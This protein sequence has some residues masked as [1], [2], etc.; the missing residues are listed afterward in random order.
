[1][2]L[3]PDQIRA[4]SHLLD[5]A[6]DLPLAERQAWMAALPA[7]MQPLLPQLQAMLASDS[8]AAPGGPD[9][10][11]LPRLHGLQIEPGAPDALAGE[12]VGPYRLLRELGRG[13][14]GSVWLAE[15]AD[16]IFERQ[17][18]LKLPRLSRSPRLAERMARERQIGARLEHPHIARLYDAGI[19]AA[20]RPYLV[21]E[22]VQGT[23]LLEYAQLQRLGIAQRIG[24]MLQ[25]CAAVAH[26]H[27]LLVVH[28]DL[29]PSNLMVGDDGNVKLLDFGIAKLLDADEGLM[30]SGSDESQRTHT[31][32]YAAPEQLR[33]EP[34]TTATDIYS[35]GVV[36][37]ELLTAHLP[38][39]D[40]DTGL[41]PDLAAVL[42]RAMRHVPAERYSSVER[43]VDDLQRV[44]QHRPVQAEPTRPSHR[45]RLFVRRHRLPLAVATCV[46]LLGLGG[47]LALARQHALEQLQEQRAVQ[48]REFLFDLLE[49]AEPMAGQQAGQVTGA[50]MVQSAVARARK[51]FIQQPALQGRLFTE[52]GIV[53]RRLELPDQALALFREGHALLQAASEPGDPGLHVAQAQLALQW[54]SSDVPDPSQP[55]DALAWQALQGCAAS[56]ASC[57][58]P[59]AYAQMALTISASRRGDEAATLEHAAQA[60]LESD[61]AFGPQDAEAAMARLHQA[62]ALRNAG[63]YTEAAAA[64]GQARSIAEGTALRAADQTSLRLYHALVQADLGQH[65]SA[66]SALQELLADRPA[67]SSLPLLQRLRAQSLYAQGRLT[68]GVQAAQLALDAGRQGN[69]E[70]EQV[71][72]HQAL[73]RLQSALGRHD[74]ALASIQ[75][76]RAGLRRLQFDPAGAEFLRAHRLA[77]EVALRAGRVA[78]AAAELAP[79]PAAH[80]AGGRT[81]APVDLAQVL[82]LQGGLARREAAFAEAARLHAEAAALLADRLPP[83]HPL[84][85]RNAFEASLAQALQPW[86]VAAPLAAAAAAYLA[87]LPADSAWRPMVESVPA[88]PAAGRYLVF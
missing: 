83:T 29:K 77:A 28:R 49:D 35:L 72:A 25:V 55:A 42:R 46:G 84:R 78:E 30:A 21:M 33:G 22:R 79:L 20:G 4:L 86:A 59:R 81:V 82:D 2:A 16:G 51:S 60:V 47:S 68:P 39:P 12:L 1:M 11:Q 24:L 43:L 75:A 70:W 52:L 80:R 65:E 18:A 8:A 15:R 13:G 44:L 58:K 34:V 19:D 88:L 7:Q 5:Q 37:H 41:D 73:A 66:L 76:L 53:H 31:P 3:S 85:L 69:D 48:A 74:A 54:A 50:Q 61:R 17:V 23:G 62:V 36:L 57:A 38:A 45:L 26:A 32:R 71:F 67:P 64:L 63:R 56:R 40:V 9:L 27:T 6:L 14:M 10:S 87:L